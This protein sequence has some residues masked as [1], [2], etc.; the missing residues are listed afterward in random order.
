MIQVGRLPFGDEFGES[1]VAEFAGEVFP[2]GGE[3]LC[4][5]VGWGDHGERILKS[6]ALDTPNL[7]AKDRATNLHTTFEKTICKNSEKSKLAALR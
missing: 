1:R 2:D 6:A 5:F 4:G 7:N 3:P